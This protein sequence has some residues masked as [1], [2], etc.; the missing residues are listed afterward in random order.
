M[1]ISNI[2]SKQLMPHKMCIHITEILFMV[3][4]LL[5]EKYCL[6]FLWYKETKIYSVKLRIYG[7][8]I[9]YNDVMASPFLS[10]ICCVHLEASK[11]EF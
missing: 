8:V 1:G 3:F 5:K 2:P 9:E 6:N 4:E 11:S 10:N 7:R